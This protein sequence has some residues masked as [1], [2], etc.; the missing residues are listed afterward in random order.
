MMVV[1][2]R[3]Y[4]V[5]SNTI[6]RSS[7]VLTY[8]DVSLITHEMFPPHLRSNSVS[9]KSYGEDRASLCNNMKIK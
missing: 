9:Y 1:C 7:V 4:C 2:R 3:L 6:G 5:Y 8:R